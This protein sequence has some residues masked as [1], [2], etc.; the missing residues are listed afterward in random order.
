MSPITMFF[1]SFLYALTLISFAT[2]TNITNAQIVTVIKSSCD[3]ALYRNTCVDALSD[4]SYF[5]RKYHSKTQM[6]KLMIAIAMKATYKTQKI[7]NQNLASTLSNSNKNIKD[8][9][10]H[11]SSSY[12]NLNSSLTEVRNIMGH[13]N[14]QMYNFRKSNVMTWLSS[15][16]TD[17]YDCNDVL[18]DIHT[19]NIRNRIRALVKLA[20]EMISSSLAV[21]S[22]L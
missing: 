19:G 18:S 11:M 17:A 1:I 10:I 13:P 16:L 15:A 2:A 21:C 22:K 8:C 6:G 12:S 20:T 4:Y 14:S 3:G 7:V 9:N 5:I